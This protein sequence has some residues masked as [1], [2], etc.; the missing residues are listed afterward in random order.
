MGSRGGRAMLPVPSP[1]SALS[2]V[3]VEAHPQSGPEP[4]HS[5]D[6]HNQLLQAVSAPRSHLLGQE[7]QQRQDLQFCLWAWQWR[8]WG[9]SKM[10]GGVYFLWVRGQ[11]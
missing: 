9:D 2:Q 11:G 3:C 7:C 1:R 8:L 6:G 10:A 4:F 5:A